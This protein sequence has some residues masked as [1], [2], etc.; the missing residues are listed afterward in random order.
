[1]DEREIQG[2]LC[3]TVTVSTPSVPTKLPVPYSMENVDPFL[4]WK[5]GDFLGSNRLCEP[6]N[7]QMN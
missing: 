5:V 6:E 1:M 4:A 2:F 3:R 7:I